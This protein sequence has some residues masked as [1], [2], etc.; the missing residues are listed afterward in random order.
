MSSKLLRSLTPRKVIDLA[1][2]RAARR[3]EPAEHNTLMVRAGA[4]V[5]DEEVIRHIGIDEAM[6]L[7]ECQRVLVTC[8]N[9]PDEGSP[10]RF[11]HEVDDDGRLEISRPIGELLRE[12][13][14]SLFFHWGLWSFHLH[15]GEKWPRDEGTP[16]ALCIGGI[17]EFQGRPFDLTDVNAELTGTDT[18]QQVLSNARGEVCRVIERTRIFDFVPLLQAMDLERPT[19]VDAETREILAE[20]P[21]EQD[22]EPVDAFWSTVLGLSCLADEP[23][24]D[25]VIEDTMNALRWGSPEELSADD[26]KKLCS[27]SLDV[28]AS[29]GAYGTDAG[30]TVDRL[31]IYRELIRQTNG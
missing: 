7:Q 4:Y 24:T 11:T 29:V 28:L 13:G 18:V 30:S 12:S 22:D 27:E 23:L 6:T 2:E 15:L 1:A 10:A 20:L 26:I 14:D 21:L 17:G 8:F 19:A 5:V 16:R 3:G 25:T 31:D 9:L